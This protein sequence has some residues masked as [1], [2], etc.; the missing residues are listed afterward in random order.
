MHEIFQAKA[1]STLFDEGLDPP[2]HIGFVEKDEPRDA[3]S[4]VEPFGRKRIAA[5][6]AGDVRRRTNRSPGRARTGCDNCTRANGD[7]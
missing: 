5:V 4:P 6:C 1:V 2:R 7:R 3:S